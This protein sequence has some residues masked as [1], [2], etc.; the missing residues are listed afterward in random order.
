MEQ[1]IY[2]HKYFTIGEFLNSSKAT[3]NK[4]NNCRI[5]R[6]IESN[7]HSLI[8]NVLDPARERFGAAMIISSGFRCDELNKLVGGVESSQH[9]TVPAADIQVSGLSNLRKLFLILS[10]MDVD[11][12]LYEYSIDKKT[13]NKTYWIHVS[14]RADGKNRHMIRDSYL[15]IK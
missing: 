9:R 7:I 11:Q 15:S 1:C 14:Y 3:E 12:L 13:G 5:T 4:I 8:E 2:N 10:E 6:E